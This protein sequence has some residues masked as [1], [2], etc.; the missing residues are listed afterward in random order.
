MK[1][2]RCNICDIE[3]PLTEF[4]VRR[5]SP[6]GVQK[7]CKVCGCALA[8]AWTKKHPRYSEVRLAKNPN[9]RKE[10]HLYYSYGLTLADFQKRFLQQKGRC[11]ICRREL[12]SPV[13]DHDHKSG[14]VRALLCPG[15]NTG[16]GIFKDSPRLFKAAIRYIKKHARKSRT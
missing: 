6:D 1:L 2:K 14:K 8:R 5:E 9:Y 15:C 3:K 4:H 16:L 13:V 11:A 10:N 7:R 12:T